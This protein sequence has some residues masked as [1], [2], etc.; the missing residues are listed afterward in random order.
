M[1]KALLIL[2]TLAGLTVLLLGCSLGGGE[3]NPVGI[4]GATSLE[5][6]KMGPP[7]AN[8]PT[9]EQYLAHEGPQASEVAEGQMRI[10]GHPVS[11]GARPT[12]MNRKLDSWGGA[13]PGYLI[14]NPDRM[15]GLSTPVKF[16]IYYHECGHQFVGGSETGADCYSVHRGVIYGWLDQRGMD[17]VCAFISTLRGDAVHPPGPKRC[18]LMRQCFADA[19]QE[20]AGIEK[21]AEN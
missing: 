15:E 9:V 2:A 13:F 19:L 16:Y 10:D 8:G 21:H 20:K 12:V 18:Q 4:G 7:D 5:P 1:N 11:C 6:S 3:G 14:L 17:Q